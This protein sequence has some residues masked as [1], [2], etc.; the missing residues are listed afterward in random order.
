MNGFE[1]Y[2]AV[3]NNEE[4]DFLPRV[5]VLMQYAAEYIGS[6]YRAFASD[7]RVLV[8]ANKAV[9]RDF[10]MDQVSTISDPYRETHGFGAEI[11]FPKN[12]VPRCLNPPLLNSKDISSMVIPDPFRGSRMFDRVQAIE[13][14]KE[15]V[16]DKLSILGWIEGP[17]AE[18]AN[19]RGITSFLMDLLD[20]ANF[21][22]DLM[23]HCLQTGINFARAQVKAGADTIG[24]GDAIA[25][26]VSPGIYENLIQPREKRLCQAIQNMGAKVRL[27]ICGNITHILPGISN[28]GVDI[29]DI[30]HMVD[31]RLARKELG[32]QIAL[33]GNIDPVNGVLSGTPEEIQDYIR[34]V[35]EE[36]GNPYMVAAGCEIPSGTP[37]KNIAALCKPIK[38]KP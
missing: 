15:T 26:Q 27:H 37:P 35:Y 9:A 2:Q 31:M 13:S 21:A 30:D 11:E 5:P 4:P 29:V 19:L 14:Y 1:R 23:D 10:G 8:K 24:V 16:Q 33:A 18:A 25:S 12:S 36:T 6:N 17:A 28:L 3:L 38:W 22:A 34:S 7:Y 20:D 32:V